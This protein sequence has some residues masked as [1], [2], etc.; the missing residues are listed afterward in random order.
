MKSKI[1]VVTL[2]IA[3]LNLQ[4]CII[5]GIGAG[6]GAWKYGNAEKE[7][8]Y[9]ECKK[10]YNDYIEKSKGANTEIMSLAAYCPGADV[11]ETTVEDAKESK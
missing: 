4:G 3:A 1:L 9:A 5:A 10:Q 2:L 6:V 7:K 11:A 8:A